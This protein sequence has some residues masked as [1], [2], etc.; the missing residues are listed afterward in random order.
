MFLAAF[1][2][3]VPLKK[4][5]RVMTRSGCPPTNETFHILI[6]AVWKMSTHLNDGLWSIIN[7]METV[8]LPY[9]PSIPKLIRD[10]LAAR[11]PNDNVVVRAKLGTIKGIDQ[12]KVPEFGGEAGLSAAI[13]LWITRQNSFSGGD[14]VRKKDEIFRVQM[15]FADDD[16]SL[17]IQ[18]AHLYGSGSFVIGPE[19]NPN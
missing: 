9:D 8:S 11:R 17:F 4:V 19:M 14:L 10:G 13:G 2:G 12:L 3:K 1:T 16:H 6:D 7:A 15:R 5:L 18:S